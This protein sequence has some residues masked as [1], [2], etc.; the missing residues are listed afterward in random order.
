M[1]SKTKRIGRQSLVMMLISVLMTLCVSAFA[2]GEKNQEPFLRLRT[3][4]FFDMQWSTEKM[5]VNDE[6]VVSGKFRLFTDWPN[7]LPKPEMVFLGNGTPGP[8]LA[9]TE[10]YINGIPATQSGKLEVDRDYEF[11]TVYKGRVPG[12]HHVHPMLNVEGA[13]PL[14]GPGKWLEIT[15]DMKDFKLG[16]T[17]IDG[18][19]I[20]NLET[21]GVGTVLTWHA[22]WFIAAL[23]YMLWW[24]RKPFL[25]P[26]FR[27]N[28]AG[29]EEELVTRGDRVWGAG[30]LVATLVVVIAGA[31]WAENKYTRTIPLQG[32]EFKV[33][34]LPI[35]NR[36]VHIAV[37]GATYDVPGRSMKFVVEV[38]NN[39]T[40]PVQVGEF[41]TS[42]LRFVNHSVPAAMA[43]VHADFPKEQVPPSGLKVDDQKPILP[44]EVRTL[45]LDATDVA[46]ELERLTAMLGDPD[47]RIGGLLFFYDANGK[48]HIANVFGP[49]LPIFSK[50]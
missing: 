50:I 23:V 27:A 26:R 30:F 31:N 1:Y 46:W 9:R 32:G 37:K 10:S 7:S 8:V 11:K 19:K 43:G 22:G 48:R 2:H 6:I 49:I 12:R 33:E 4:H 15:G 21:W 39:G 17:T 20:D 5:K 44:G 35:D 29:H 40:V 25:M 13:G 36:D 16:M 38:K 42:N 47:N 24:L 41:S 45:K 14:L 34:P 3:V 28:E 18:T